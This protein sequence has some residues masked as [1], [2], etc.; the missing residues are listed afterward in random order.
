MRRQAHG[1]AAAAGAANVRRRGREMMRC[2][3]ARE[4]IAAVLGM[5]RSR[6]ER[7]C[8]DTVLA[9]GR[10]ARFNGGFSSTL[11]GRVV[12]IER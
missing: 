8:I 1:S 6:V 10:V 9:N 5:G 12:T 4:L 7:R 2:R 3:H 11:A